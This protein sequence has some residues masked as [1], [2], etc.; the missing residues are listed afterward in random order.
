LHHPNEIGRNENGHRKKHGIPKRRENEE[1]SRKEKQQKEA[2]MGRI[3]AEKLEGSY[4]GYLVRRAFPFP[5]SR[6]RLSR[7]RRYTC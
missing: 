4:R 3:P 6:A 7:N 2:E 1:E 5:V